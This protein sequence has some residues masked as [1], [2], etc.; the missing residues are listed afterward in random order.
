MAVR[1]V[2]LLSTPRVLGHIHELRTDMFGLLARFNRECGDVGRMRF[3]RTSLVLVN[4]PELVS[5]LLVEKHAGMHKSRFVRA[6]LNPLVGDGLF[7]SDG[8]LW[9]SQRKLMAPIFQPSKIADFDSSMTAMTLRCIDTWSSGRIVDVAREMTRITMTVAGKTLFDEDTFEETDDIGGALT[10]ALQWARRASMSSALALQLELAGAVEGVSRRTGWPLK[11]AVESLEKPIMWPGKNTRELRGAIATIDARVARM[12]AD[13]RAGRSKARTDL[14]SRL[15]DA[16]DAEGRS[17][18]SDQQLRDEIVTLFVAGHETTAAALAWC[19]S[20]LA[21]TPNVLAEL[22]REVDALGGRTPTAA[23]LPLLPLA[24]R[25]FKETLR[26]YP[27]VPI[28]ERITTEPVEI[29]GYSLEPGVYVGVFPW[30]VHHRSDLWP[31][32]DRFDP[33]R[34]LPEAEAARHRHAWIPFGAGPRVCIGNHFALQEGPLVLATIVQR[35]RLELVD[36]T[37]AL[38]PDP[39]SPTLRPRGPVQMRV[40]R[41]SATGIEGRVSPLE[42]PPASSSSGGMSTTP[43]L[44]RDGSL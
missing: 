38:V 16:R 42:G 35:A 7:T 2:P 17:A 22:E 23:D 1:D 13:R 32:S 15:L 12:I 28:Y 6:S 31:D 39:E 8:S 18:M 33:D 11:R 41:R 34:F 14:L 40:Y 10:V 5:Q 44:R 37:L 26:L 3:G 29:A 4:T 25:V 9:R 43:L 27:P 19:F 36:P 21:R 30:T 20:L 24:T